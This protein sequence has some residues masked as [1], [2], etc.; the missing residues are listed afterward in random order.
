MNQAVGV[1]FFASEGAWP[2]LFRR[3]ELADCVRFLTGSGNAG[4]RLL[5][6]A[7]PSGSGKSFF[8]RELVV[9]CADA[10]NAGTVMYIDTPPTDLEAS[11]LFKTIDQ[12]ISVHRNATRDAPNAVSKACADKWRK[13]KYPPKP[14]RLAY[15]YGVLRELT[16]LLPSAYGGVLKAFLPAPA[17]SQINTNRD[18]RAAI[19]FLAS[20]SCANPVVIVLD[21]I[22][23]L[24]HS[25]LEMLEN[26]LQPFGP[27]LRLIAIERTAGRKKL[28]WRPAISNLAEKT[29]A[30][31]A[32][33]KDEIQQLIECVMPEED[34]PDQLADA[35]FRR[36]EGNLKYVWFQL[37]LIA[38]R[39]VSQRGPGPM[40][41]YE[42]VIRSLRPSDQLVLR[43][44]VMLFGGITVSSLVALFKVSH[45]GLR[46]D[47]IVIAVADLAALGLIIINGEHKDR[48]KL[49]HEVIS[50]LVDALTPEEEKEEVRAMLV[51]ALAK[52][53]DRQN[54]DRN[55][56][57][58]SDRLV[59]IV[60]EQEVRSNAVLQ[61]HLVAF[62]Y[63][64]ER[65]EHFAY[66]STLLRNGVY[67][68]VL[69]L[70]PADCLRIL[71][72]SVQKSS[73]FHFGLI[74]TERVRKDAGHS[75]L[76]ALYSAKYLVQLFRY[77]E[78]RRALED[79]G[80]SKECEVIEFNIAL[81][82]CQDERAAALAERLLEAIASNEIHSE[83]DLLVLRNSGHLF[84]PAK[85]RQLVE[86]ALRGFAR[87][88]KQFGI[89]TCRNNLGIVE[90]ADQRYGQARQQLERARQMLAAL[91]SDEIYQPLVNLAGVAAVTGNFYLA[92][93]HL[94]AARQ[95]APAA[96]M[97]DQAMLDFNDAV[98]ALCQRQ[99][100][101]ELALA[102]FRQ[103]YADAARTSDLRFIEV[104]AWF[105]AS[106]E[107]ILT[108][109]R[110]IN[111]SEAAMA[112]ILR[113]DTAGLELFL[114][115]E[116]RGHR[117]RAPYILSPHWRY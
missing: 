39:R 51:A 44:I 66:L 70:L 62:L 26:E 41:S 69:D 15:L 43:F 9:Q 54:G 108:A 55:D 72:D 85:A 18:A 59:G 74:A 113:A 48:I 99:L 61:S 46:P 96:L 33:S 92:Q 49:E 111:Y 29:I 14:D 87:L 100:P 12:I 24:P 101:A 3:N 47:D 20:Y 53:L 76:A 95:A 88:G 23:F 80:Q 102:R 94:Q 114:D 83:Y 27:E 2:F 63:S 112:R 71:L 10:L 65:K 73:L 82:L 50:S 5:R 32:I 6:V 109:E 117:L 67:W 34:R 35:V 90:L 28:D 52:H 25:V 97:M 38:E 36:S 77:D 107:S 91:N 110:N 4:P 57:V 104:V 17:A 84:A 93:T 11:D 1:E 45:L 22:Q 8:T 13:K 56:D 58:F 98:L 116:L 31:G 64:Q 30:I 106:L 75:Q 115:V 89:A 16:A 40:E 78:A 19:R 21:N 68:D 105:T 103:V 60:H 37:K 42:D 79:A 86:A 7:G 81:N